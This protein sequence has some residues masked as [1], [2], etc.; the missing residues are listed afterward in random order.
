MRVF[1]LNLLLALLWAAAVSPVDLAHLVVG[2]AAGYLVLWLARPALGDTAYFSKLPQATGF[3]AFFLWEL[4][5]ATVRVAWDVVAPRAYRRPG[6]VAVRFAEVG[7]AVRAGLVVLFLVL[8]APVASHLIARA[9]YRSGVPP[10][11]RHRHR[12]ARRRDAATG[13]A[14]RRPAG[15]PPASRGP[16]TS[17][18]L[19]AGVVGTRR[20]RDT[21]GT[22]RAPTVAASAPWPLRGG[23]SGASRPPPPRPAPESRT[24]GASAKLMPA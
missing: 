2:F 4:L 12:R 22:P 3:A 8:T 18:R 11:G 5:L 6:V 9:G 20:R 13:G 19:T 10:R 16:A 1:L 23:D 21:V 24:R 15:R 14:L 7:V 17:P